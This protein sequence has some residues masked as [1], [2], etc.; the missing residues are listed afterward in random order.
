MMDSPS[1]SFCSPT[2][3]ASLPA[4]VET[5]Q[6]I[7]VPTPVSEEPIPDPETVSIIILYSVKT[8]DTIIL[9]KTTILNRVSIW[10]SLLL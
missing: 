8:G 10:N 3:E 6:E 5:A 4:H 2:L 1:E 7:A 9:R